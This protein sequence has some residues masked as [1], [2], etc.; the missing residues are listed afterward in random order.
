MAPSEFVFV[1][2]GQMNPHEDVIIS[3]NGGR[4]DVSMQQRVRQPIYWEETPSSVRRCTWF[5]KSDGENRFLPYEEGLSDRLEVNHAHFYMTV[6]LAQ[7]FLSLPITSVDPGF[8][9]GSEPCMWI[10]FF[11]PYLAAGVFPIVF[12]STHV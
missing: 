4:F 8:E 5:Y 11:S 3:T 1:L 7:W 12:F 9:P 2:I 6:R 10:G